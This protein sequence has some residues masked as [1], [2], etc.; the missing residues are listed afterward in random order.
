MAIAGSQVTNYG[1]FPIGNGV[2][3]IW[4]TVTGPTSYTSGGEV[5]TKAVASSIWGA[6]DI[7]V[8]ACSPA[9]GST[10]ATGAM[11]NFEP[12]P[13]HA[14]SAGEFHFYNA[15]DAHAHDFLVKGGTA[16]AGTD[17]L[18]IKTVIIGKEAA[19]DATSLGA[20]SATKGGVL[21]TAADTAA[22][23]GASTTNYS[24]F[25]FHI[26]GLATG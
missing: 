16:A 15:V 1:H 22:A 5:I 25:T 20:D 13:T 14:T 4:G 7:K 21:A 18:N 24:T 10:W 26:F 3:M 6:S 19:T 23:E 9:G 11:V 8:L 17:A 2:R 12:T